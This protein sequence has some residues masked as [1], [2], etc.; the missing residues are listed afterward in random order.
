MVVQLKEAAAADGRVETPAHA[1]AL[2]ARVRYSMD[3]ALQEVGGSTG[4][5]QLITSLACIMIFSV[6]S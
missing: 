5:F 4:K 1:D 2:A 6:G 3:D